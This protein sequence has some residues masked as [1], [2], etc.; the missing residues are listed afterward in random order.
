MNAE[1]G[2]D[3]QPSEGS[4]DTPWWQSVADDP[5]PVELRVDLPHPARMYDYYLGG[6]DNFPADREAA[7]QARAVAPNASVAARANRAFMARAVRHLAGEAGI[8]Q[9]L[10]IGTGIP[11]SPNLHEIAQEAVEGARVVYVDNDPIVLTHARALLTGT[12][13]GRTAYLDADVRDVRRILT[14][15]EVT[16]TLDLSRPV[17]LSLLAVGHFLP[18]SDDPGA[19][20]RR[21]VD[22]L[23]A[24]SYLVLSHLTPDHDPSIEAGAKAYRARGIPLR[25]RTRAEI[26]ALFGGL[27]LLD[28]GLVCVHRWRPD[29]TVPTDLTDAQVSAYGAIGRKG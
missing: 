1:I 17:A 21:L 19:I 4:G 10:D 28:P 24:G 8:D 26:E 5:K 16:D 23:P 6:K 13:A 9:F 27:E 29:A 25:P 18:D 2:T 22:A 7:E 14:A 20:V 11:T 15:P 3:P 12:P